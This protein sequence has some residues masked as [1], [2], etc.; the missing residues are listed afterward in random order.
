[1]VEANNVGPGNG[2]VDDPGEVVMPKKPTILEKRI[3]YRHGLTAGVAKPPKG[4][5]MLTRL[6]KAKG[7]KKEASVLLNRDPTRPQEGTE[8]C[9]ELEVDKLMDWKTVKGA[10]TGF[11]NT[12]VTCYINAT[13]QCLTYT[14]PLANYLTT[15]KSTHKG[16]G[17]DWLAIV[18]SVTRFSTSPP[19][20]RS[21]HN[22]VDFN[23]NLRRLSTS[24][25]RGR[26]EDAQEFLNFLIDAMHMYQLSKYSDTKD[27][28]VQETTPIKT[29]FGGYFKSCIQWSKAEEISELRKKAEKTKKPIPPEALSTNPQSATYEPFAFL[30]LEI[31]GHSVEKSLQH[32]AKPEHLTGENKYVTPSGVKVDAQK[33]FT[34][35]RSPRILIVHLKRFL[36]N[37]W[38]DTKKVNKFTEFSVD[39][40]MKNYTS[41]PE[42]HA[43]KLYGVVVHQGG[44]TESG[45]YIAFIT[46]PNGLWYRMDDEDVTQVSLNVVLKQQAYL[47]FYK[48]VPKPKVAKPLTNG[49]S[50]ANG[51]GTN[52]HDPNASPSPVVSARQKK[53]EARRKQLEEKEAAEAEQRAEE[54][55]KQKEVEDAER[56]ARHEEKMKAQ[57]EAKRERVQKAQEARAE[58]RKIKENGV[59]VKRR[60][61]TIETPLETPAE[62]PVEAPVETPAANGVEAPRKKRKVV[63]KVKKGRYES[64]ALNAQSAFEMPEDKEAYWKDTLEEDRLMK[65]RVAELDDETGVVVD[66]ETQKFS[67]ELVNAKPVEKAGKA[68]KKRKREEPVAEETPLEKAKK[69]VAPI[70]AAAVL[71]AKSQAA[72]TTWQGVDQTERNKL[73]K[74]GK[75]MKKT[76]KQI[77]DEEWNKTLDRGKAKKLPKSQR[78]SKGHSAGHSTFQEGFEKK[79]AES[80]KEK[81]EKAMG[82]WVPVEKSARAQKK[83]ALRKKDEGNFQ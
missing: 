53:F 37:M 38:G 35:Y 17:V 50:M 52:H 65:E 30:T 58:K 43:Y 68:A 73:L 16:A 23:K 13:L 64:A 55:R 76:A 61:V 51:N 7:E 82:T 57:Q 2:L 75:P 45:H 26:L 11:R 80:E 1:M 12:S 28:L 6:R 67:E 31:Q 21:V 54:A 3:V 10:D 56:R 74:V 83:L 69:E 79:T 72:A 34:V 25:R 20:P 32:F 62:T 47:L 14:A 78:Q 40:D 18:A 46:A 15:Y 77:A 24:L 70:K 49:V 59:G 27:P 81:M 5:V 22:P 29:I 42:S 71:E 4:A 48:R 19:K 63:R 44:G 36:S 39:L 9:D 8:L 66:A 41:G 60:K 33:S